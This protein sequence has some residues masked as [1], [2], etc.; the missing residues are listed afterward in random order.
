MKQQGGL[1]HIDQRPCF[2]DSYLK[3][4]NPCPEFDPYIE[5]DEPRHVYSV[6]GEEWTG[7]VTGFVHNFFPEFKE[8]AVIEGMMASPNWP[9]NKY[10]GMTAQEIKDVWEDIRTRASTLGTEMHAYIEYYYNTA[11]DAERDVIINEYHT[12]E[13]QYFLQFHSKEVAHMKPWRTELRVF[14][15]E[16]RL[17]GSVDMLYISP[18]STQQCPLLVMYDWKRSKEIKKYGRYGHGK[19]PVHHLPNT[20]LWHYNLQLNVYKTLIERNTPW[21]IESMWLGVFHPVQEDY[22]TFRVHDFSDEVSRM[23]EMR[24]LGIE[25]DAHDQSPETQFFFNAP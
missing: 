12:L 9:D 22:L 16:L 7:S 2:S 13:F 20:N 17:A 8:D 1:R 24:K 18:N 19:G 21:R 6:D 5:F 4:L 15:R 14:D 25:P 3:Q 11:N 10:Y 23:L